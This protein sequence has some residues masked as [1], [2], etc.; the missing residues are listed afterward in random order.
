MTASLY[1]ADFMSEANYFSQENAIKDVRKYVTYV[2]TS[3]QVFFIGLII[4]V[5]NNLAKVQ[6]P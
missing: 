2:R 5:K 1:G 6:L 3:T 4:S